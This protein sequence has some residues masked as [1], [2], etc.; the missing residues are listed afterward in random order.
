MN[1]TSACDAENHAVTFILTICTAGA[2]SPSIITN[3]R[4]DDTYCASFH[5]IQED[6]PVSFGGQRYPAIFMT[7]QSLPWICALISVWPHSRNILWFFLYA[8]LYRDSLGTLNIPSPRKTAQADDRLLG[9]MLL[10]IHHA[11]E[12]YRNAQLSGNSNTCILWQSYLCLLE[13][14]RMVLLCL[15]KCFNKRASD[16]QLCRSLLSPLQRHCFVKSE[17]M[18]HYWLDKTSLALP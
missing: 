11:E 8:K 1:S 17:S 14:Q 18:Q 6:V 7:N 3:G 2:G 12:A 10:W 9:N 13:L 15:V 4:T 16:K 5:L